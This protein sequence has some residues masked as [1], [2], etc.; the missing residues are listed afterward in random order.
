MG[1]QKDFNWDLTVNVQSSL[2]SNGQDKVIGFGE[3]FTILCMFF[4]AINM[5]KVWDLIHS[6]NK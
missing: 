3:T 1:Q 4:G 6:T 5:G 2:P